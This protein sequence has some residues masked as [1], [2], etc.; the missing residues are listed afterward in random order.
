MNLMLFIKKEILAIIFKKKSENIGEPKDN[1][2][3][4]KGFKGGSF[5]SLIS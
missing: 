2:N 3:I 5:I 4:A 1:F